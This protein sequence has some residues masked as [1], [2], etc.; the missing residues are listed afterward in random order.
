MEPAVQY[1]FGKAE[2]LTGRKIIGELFAEGNSFFVSPFKVLWLDTASNGSS[3]AKLLITVPRRNFKNAV[4]R[5]RIKR[6]IREAYRL[7]KHELIAA[8][9]AKGIE[10]A[11]AIVMT[12]HRLPDFKETE[13]I[14]ILVLQRLQ[15]EHEKIAG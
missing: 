5:N 7:H 14:I 2:K 6:L 9:S 4:H 8:L 11:I 1:T 3:S 12:G 10:C 13:Q 15:Q